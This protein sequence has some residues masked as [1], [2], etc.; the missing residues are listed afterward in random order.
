[1][2]DKYDILDVVAVAEIA[3][4]VYLALKFMGV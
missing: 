3:A 4:V 2:N 1:M